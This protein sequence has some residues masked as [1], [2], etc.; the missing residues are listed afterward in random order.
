MRLVH[1]DV[2]E[3]VQDLRAAVGRRAR[4]HQ[5]RP[6]VD[7]RGVDPPG[8]EV[9]IRH[10]RKQKR[11]VRRHAADAELGERAA[12]PSHR[13]GEVASAAGQLDQ[14][15]VEVRA[16]LRPQVRRAVQP[17][18]GTTG[19][20]VAGDATG[21]G[22]ESVGRVLGGDP[23][24]QRSATHLHR[25][26]LQAKVF[27]RLAVGDT[28]LTADQ[29]D[30]GDLLGDSVLDLDARVHL[31]EDVVTA[32]VEQELDGA[33][34]GVVDLSGER[35]CIGANALPQFVGQVGRRGQ[36]DDLLVPALHAAVAFEEV[37]DVAVRVGKDLHLDV[38]GIDHR[39]FEIHGG[40][41]E[42]R[43]CFPAGGLDRLGQRVGVCHAPHPAAAAAGHRLDEQR[44]LYFICGLDELVHR[45]RRRRRI[46]HR[47]SRGAGRRDRSRLVAGELQ[48]LGA[49]SDERDARVGA[50]LG[51]F[52]VLGQ[53]AVSGVDRIGA[54]PARG[55]DDL[56]DR[57]VR[58]YRM[59]LLADL[60]RLVGLEPVHGV[61]V[62]VRI[63]RDGRDAQFVGGAERA[64]RDFAAVGDEDLVDH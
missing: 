37:D 61:A 35:D 10:H 53:E 59:A 54:G 8:A 31:D 2:G 15:R 26:L 27:E 28:H 48:D 57:Q 20:A 51:Q 56:V 23:A 39:L 4:G 6:L 22:A 38:T 14:H 41:A 64:D 17:N 25:I 18:A 33:R 29:V 1:G 63:H 44:E 58:P 46:Q 30:V 62:L 9:R 47:Q 19:R 60:I 5:P 36:F 11:D 12:G 16:D 43:L 40:V 7:E 52:R 34:V 13:G 55:R 42:R 32:L 21:V 24:L 45:R 50:G 49:G 3:I